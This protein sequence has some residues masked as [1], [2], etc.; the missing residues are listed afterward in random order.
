MGSHG[1]CHFVLYFPFLHNV[2]IVHFLLSCKITFVLQDGKLY[3]SV[4]FETRLINFEN[5]FFL[6]THYQSLTLSLPSDL[7]HIQSLAP[8]LGGVL[9]S[10][11]TAISISSSNWK[12]E[13]ARS[14]Q[15]KP[16]AHMP[17]L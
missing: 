11:S 2:H 15:K 5:L 10:F 6:Y 7:L 14:C 1:I 9:V 16:R 17:I 3:L 13:K 8:H 4:T 12:E